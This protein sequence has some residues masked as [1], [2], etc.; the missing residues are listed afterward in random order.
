MPNLKT[1]DQVRDKAKAILGFDD[2]E[3]DVVQ[4]TGQLTTFNMLYEHNRNIE[5]QDG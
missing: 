3:K 1:E 5:G 2:G 4:D